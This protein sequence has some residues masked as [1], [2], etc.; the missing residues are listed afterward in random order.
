MTVPSN[1]SVPKPPD[2]ILV[3]VSDRR[4]LTSGAF[5]FQFQ[6]ISGMYRAHS[7]ESGHSKLQNLG[8]S[9]VFQLIESRVY[10]CET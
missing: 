8:H 7:A 5:G 6:N 4:Q 3:A 1:L 9:F 2:T 10:A